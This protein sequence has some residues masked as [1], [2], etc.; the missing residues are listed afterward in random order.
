MLGTTI[1][2]ITVVIIAD[3][4]APIALHTLCALHAQITSNCIIRPRAS[5]PAPDT[6]TCTIMD[7]AMDAVVATDAVSAV[8]TMATAQHA[9]HTGLITMALATAGTHPTPRAVSVTLVQMGVGA[10]LATLVTVV[11][12]R[13]T[14][15]IRA[16]TSAIV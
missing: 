10:V 13:S 16:T 6:N 1:M 4:I 15:I 14:C 9:R 12:V 2:A 11:E 3:Q 8:N 7:G 5:V